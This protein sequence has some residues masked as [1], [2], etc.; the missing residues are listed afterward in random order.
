MKKIH[1]TFNNDKALNILAGSI[2]IAA[3]FA[4]S[5]GIYEIFRRVDKTDATKSQRYLMDCGV[6][7]LTVA[8]VTPLTTAGVKSFTKAA[9]DKDKLISIKVGDDSEGTEEKPSDEELSQQRNKIVEMIRKLVAEHGDIGWKFI[10][11]FEYSGVD[12]YI[13]SSAETAIADDWKE[14]LTELTDYNNKLHKAIGDSYSFATMKNQLAKIA[15][16]FVSEMNKDLG[17]TEE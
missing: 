15:N 13:I 10:G 7:A 6:R 3:S 9:L 16:D 1:I 17:K 14:F 4:A 8:A 5:I 2:N 12:G 11:M